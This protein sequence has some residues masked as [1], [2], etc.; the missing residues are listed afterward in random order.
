M[1]KL[2]AMDTQS[3]ALSKKKKSRYVNCWYAKEEMLL[4]ERTHMQVRKM[5]FCEKEIIVN[6][7]SCDLLV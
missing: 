1:L 3:I 5:N 7:S 4:G 6:D 2:V